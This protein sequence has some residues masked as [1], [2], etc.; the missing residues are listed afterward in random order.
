MNVQCNRCGGEISPLAKFCR[1]CGITLEQTRPRE[2]LSSEA[3]GAHR[4]SCTSC[5]EKM[6]ANAVFCR[7]CGRLLQSPMSSGVPSPEPGR[8]D[9]DRLPKA[10][11]S[12][13]NPKPTTREW[14]LNG[15]TVGQIKTASIWLGRNRAAAVVLGL[16]TGGLAWTLA[17]V[18]RVLDEQSEPRSLVEIWRRAHGGHLQ[19]S[20][21]ALFLGSC[22]ALFSLLTTGI[23]GVIAAPLF[24]MAMATSVE[25]L[26]CFRAGQD[27][28]GWLPAEILG[29]RLCSQGWLTPRLEETTRG[30][31]QWARIT[32]CGLWSWGLGS[33]MLY[34]AVNIV[35]FYLLFLLLGAIL[36]GLL[37]INGGDSYPE[38]GHAPRREYV[39]PIYGADGERIREGSSGPVVATVRGKQIKAKTGGT[40][41]RV[42]ATIE[43]NRIKQG[44]G[45]LLADVLYT[46]EGDRIKHGSGGTGA[47]V[48]AVLEGKQIK[49][50]PGGLFAEVL[51][52]RE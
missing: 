16:V 14:A 45:G 21:A 8:L 4:S 2:E 6:S 22:L 38:R 18:G 9:L 32:T 39:P 17:C 29:A 12:Y 25:M 1:H 46:I 7:H 3:S 36:A 11:A 51:F 42:I 30:W 49:A 19:L 27:P 10:S 20:A 34:C 15:R 44:N 48:A 47:N 5:G 23:S 13:P 35:I 33:M 24:I 41:D 31:P 50:P 52:T 37:S 28:F 26:Y 43:G 40:W